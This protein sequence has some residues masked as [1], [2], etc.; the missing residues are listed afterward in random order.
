MLKRDAQELQGNCNTAD[1]RR[2][3]HSDQLHDLFLVAVGALED[4]RPGRSVA[5]A[6]PA[7]GASGAEAS[8][9]GLRRSV[10]VAHVAPGGR[11][12]AMTQLPLVAAN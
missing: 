6:G 5:K 8:L 1:V 4:H 9:H 12:L 11:V 7:F 10:D 3:E 2:I